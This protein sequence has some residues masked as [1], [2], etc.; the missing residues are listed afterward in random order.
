[1]FLIKIYL[2]RIAKQSIPVLGS[3][4]ILALF[5]KMHELLQAWRQFIILLSSVEILLIIIFVALAVQDY[6]LPLKNIKA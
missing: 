3:A 5:F 2:Y 1:M 4:I 6:Y